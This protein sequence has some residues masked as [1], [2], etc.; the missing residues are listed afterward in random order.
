[1]SHEPAPELF[2]P[3]RDVVAERLGLH[4]PE[5]RWTDLARGLAAAAPDLGFGSRDACA[6]WLATT[7]PT[8]DQ[9]DV[10]ARHLTVGETMVYRDPASFEL[11][12]REILPPLVAA[13]ASTSRC[14]RLWSAGCCTGEEAYSLAI[15]C[16]RTVPDLATWNVS[17]LG[18]DVNAGFLQTAERGEYG[19][20][21]FRGTP[22][23]VRERFFR[24]VAGQR[25]AVAP[26]VRRLVRFGHLNLVEAAYPSVHNGTDALDVVFCRNVLM[27]L[28][29][30]HQRRVVDRLHRCLS[31]GGALFVSPAEADATLL[32]SYAVE[33]REGGHVGRK[34]AKPP[35][36]ATRPSMPTGAASGPLSPPSAPRDLPTVVPPPHRDRSAAPG[37][38]P[39]ASRLLATARRH[40]DQGRLD[41][42][43]AV[44]QQAIAV[45][46]A[47][48]GAHFLMA[49]VCVELQRF[50][51]A[52]AALGRVLYLDRDFVLAH[53]ALG[54]VCQRLGR[55][56][57]AR[58]HFALALRL[59][60]TRPCDD[61]VP[62]SGGMTCGRLASA[63]HARIG[64]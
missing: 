15:A 17:V 52:V 34:V 41:E 62:E 5:E 63:V 22:D 59:L 8:R 60:S 53:Q 47:N 20:W 42:A 35:T 16:L 3:V 31:E 9:L 25:R 1:M 51:E 57:E 29:P 30:A 2:G 27:Y 21:S 7:A 14:L 28:T 38:A 54:D 44:C 36:P 39:E 45:D 12:E 46:L 32:S 49:M 19:P 50:D 18:T 40:A 55:T 37:A 10:L 6:S 48:T 11:L 26:D 64:G 33:M 61:I 24:P 4:Y 13:R 58:R 43:L 56:R 23:V